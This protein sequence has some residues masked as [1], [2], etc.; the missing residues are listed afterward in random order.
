[1]K[2][3][4]NPDKDPG[5]RILEDSV[6]IDNEPLVKDK[7]YK[8]CTKSYLAKGKDGYR[9]FSK[10]KVLVDE[11][12]GP[13]LNTIV[14]NHFRS[15]NIV[16]GVT[17]SKSSHRQSLVM[18]HRS[19]EIIDDGNQKSSLIS[20][21][22]EHISISPK[23]EGRITMVTEA[24]EE[25]KSDSLEPIESHLN[26]PE[27]EKTDQ[28]QDVE[29]STRVALETHKNQNVDYV[30]TSDK[31][32]PVENV[33]VTVETLLDNSM[34]KLNNDQNEDIISRNVQ[35]RADSQTKEIKQ[36]EEAGN[37]DQLLTAKVKPGKPEQRIGNSLGPD[38]ATEDEY[39]D[40]WEAVKADD[41]DV[42]ENLRKEKNI[43]FTRCQDNKTILHLGAER[44]AVKVV[45]YLLTDGKMDPN[46]KD[47]ILQGVPL[48]G[49]AEYGS[50][51]AARV[52]LEHGAEIN[53]QDLIGNT[54]LHIAC[55]HEQGKI[56]TFLIDQGADKTIKNS[57]GETPAV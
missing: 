20:L 35:N 30:D 22:K 48:H 8:V 15:I 7:R 16:R 50:T 36:H 31:T 10:G 37:E 25:E 3:S 29:N 42:V 11:E 12:D 44:N 27:V 53:R 57:D 19:S 39:W 38:M 28:D 9:V 40:L 5:C 49:A 47:E 1:M 51:D 33:T 21:E 32:Q 56:K 24:D 13:I 23:V 54:A 46:V 14:R 52:L 45:K 6:S 4:F 17:K 18:R 41:I 34:D 2:F 43:R 26:G 55:E